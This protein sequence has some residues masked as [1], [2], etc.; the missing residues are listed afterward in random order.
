M[1]DD[2]AN[3]FVFFGATGDLAYE[4]IFPALQ[5][6]TRAGHLDMPIIG[7]AKDNW[8]LDQLVARARQSVT[9]HGGLDADAF[10]K[11]VGRLAYITGDYQDSGTF[12]RL[13]QAL[14]SATRPVFYLAIP[15]SLFGAVAAGLAKAGC[16]DRARLVVEKP[17]GRDLAS[18]RLL[19]Q[20]LQAAFP[21]GAIYRIDHFLGKEPVQN[22]LFFR[23][24]NAFLEPIWNR[25]YVDH[26]QIT[27]AEAFGVRGRGRFYEEVGALRDV[28]QNHLLQLLTML[29]MEAPVANEAVAVGDAKLALLRA[30]RPLRSTDVVRGQYRGY[31]SEPGVA[32]QSQVET[33]VAVRLAIDNWRWAGVP[34][35]IR[36]G[37]SLPVTATEVR[38]RLKAPPVALFG[39]AAVIQNEFTFQLAPDVFIALRALAKRPGDAM[40]GDEV[41]L[42][43]HYHPSVQ[44]AP[45]ERLL[46]DAIRGDRTLFGTEDQVEEA[47]RIVDPVLP[48]GPLAVYDPQRWGPGEA[49]RLAVDVGG[50]T[51]PDVTTVKSDNA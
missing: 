17:F 28:F 1:S 15:P 9:D 38:V 18:A 21:E 11:L 4:Q 44:M 6:L 3:A 50:W 12:E 45:Y 42:V 8:T 32:P 30:I 31:T 2:Q 23:F 13:R 22:L 26:V 20:V 34:F 41:R 33:Y 35:L 27:M 48:D 10:A 46:G 43:E 37:K 16:A 40:V 29:T 19:N 51:E 49:D 25:N 14:G 47:W 7:V 5:A 39:A 36:T 24:A